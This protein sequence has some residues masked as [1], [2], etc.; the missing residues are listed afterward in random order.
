MLAYV[1]ISEELYDE[2]FIAER[3]KGFA[4]FREK[5]LNDPYANPKFFE[6]IEGYEYLSK[7]IPKVARE[8][9]LKKSMIF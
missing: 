2:S 3:T 9:A 6:Q 1:I 4:E 7:M 5:I 8:Y